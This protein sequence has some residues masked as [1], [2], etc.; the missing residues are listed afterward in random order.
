MNRYLIWTSLLNFSW[1]VLQLPLYTIWADSSGRD[2]AFAVV[3]CT[4]GDVMITTISLVAAVILAGRKEWPDRRYRAV[5]VTAIL[6]GLTYTIYSEWNNT[7]V[8]RSWAYAA[9]MPQLWGIGLSPIAQWII[10]P[11]IA[12]WRLYR[13]RENLN[14]RL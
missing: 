12:F 7:V 4:V 6:T 13:P 10:V 3:H 9:S 14:A 5:A 8:T 11:G 2:I 1:E